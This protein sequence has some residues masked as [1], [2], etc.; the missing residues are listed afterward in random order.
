MSVNNLSNIEGCFDSLAAAPDY[1]EDFDSLLDDG[2]IRNHIAS[3]QWNQRYHYNINSAVCK[4]DSPKP[5]ITVV[6]TGEVIP[7]QAVEEYYV[8]VSTIEKNNRRIKDLVL[9]ENTLM[10]EKLGE[11]KVLFDILMKKKMLMN[12]ND[13][14]KSLSFNYIKNYP[15]IRE[16]SISV[17]P[18]VSSFVSSE[19]PF[20]LKNVKSAPVCMDYMSLYPQPLFM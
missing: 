13:N 11:E 1:I 2:T 15:K 17:H 20:N 4:E 7:C 5:I 12:L 6:E 18:E 10:E 8:L 19:P 14:L 16:Y 9:A 3:K